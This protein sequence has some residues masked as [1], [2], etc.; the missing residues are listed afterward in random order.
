[1]EEKADITKPKEEPASGVDISLIRW[2]LSLTPYERLMHLQNHVNA[3]LKIRH[4]NSSV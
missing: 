4:A 2:H 3:I 1:M